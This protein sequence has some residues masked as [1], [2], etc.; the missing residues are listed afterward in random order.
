MYEYSELNVQDGDKL[1]NTM[2][3]ATAMIIRMAARS[4][5]H[6]NCFY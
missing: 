2:A 3:I 6:F 4:I 1:E 5:N